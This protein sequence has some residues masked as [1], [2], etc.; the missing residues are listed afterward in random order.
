M[1][2]D[3]VLGGLVAVVVAEAVDASGFHTRAREPARVA[4]GVVAAA[5]WGVRPGRAVTALGDLDRGS[6]PR[7]R[8][9]AFLDGSPAENHSTRPGFLRTAGMARAPRTTVDSD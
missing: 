6:A 9:R 7:R 2:V 5:Q 8:V 1:D 3:G 4:R